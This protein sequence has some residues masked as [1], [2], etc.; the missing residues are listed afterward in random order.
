M[1]EAQRIDFRAQ[2]LDVH[3]VLGRVL[4]DETTATV[5]SAE[6]H[7]T[8]DR[9]YDAM[10]RMIERVPVWLILISALALGGGTMVGYR[11][12]VE[13]LGEKIGEHHM[14]PA[15]GFSAQL[16]AIASIGAADSWGMPVSTTHVLTSGV[17][18]A[19]ESS[20]DRVQWD[21]IGRILITW[22]TTLPGTV[23]LSFV[24]AMILHVMLG[25]V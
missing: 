2:M 21:M 6:E 11:R 16:A 13:T 24:M 25:G 17:A 10:T 19:V 14:T 22:V 18:G 8:L 15:Q 12:I 1:S 20:G 4:A 3:R 23:A 5:L 9:S 7:A